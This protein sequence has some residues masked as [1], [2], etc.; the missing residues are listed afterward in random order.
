MSFCPAIFFAR[1]VGVAAVLTAAMPVPGQQA[2]QYTRP[3]DQDASNRVDVTA[4]TRIRRLSSGAF[5]APSPLFGDKTPTVSFDALP[6]SPNPNAVPAVTAMQWRKFLE[7]KKNWTLQTPEEILNLPTPEKNMGLPDPKEDP[8]LSAEERFLQRQ[9]RLAAAGATN[10]FHHPDASFLRD[11]SAMN[12]FQPPVD[13][14]RF[15]QTMG[16]AVPGATKN[17]N[18]LFNMNPDMPLDFNHQSDSAWAS[19]FST[20]EPLPKATPEQLEGMDRFRALM[21]PS[22][23][24]EKSAA[25][26]RVPYQ[27]IDAPN[28]N[29]QT[30]PAYN[31]AGRSFSALESVGGK[32]TGLTPLPGITGPQRIPANKPVPLVQPPP[33][34]SDSPQPYTL[35]QRSF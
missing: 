26:S 8:N 15:V 9:D 30:M 21:E 19:P 5:N 22:A 12:R 14:R 20:P 34:L 17:L 31:P 11:D 35:L 23:A 28:P 33:W 32:P 13:S 24:P 10:G 6:G 7:G 3:A 25:P 16:G 4:P 18:P 2:I 27:P 29:L 1:W